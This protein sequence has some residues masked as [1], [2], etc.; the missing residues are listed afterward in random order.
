MSAP[1]SHSNS[2]WPLGSLAVLVAVLIA[3]GVGVASAILSPGLALDLISLWPGLIPALI[4]VVVVS[5]RRAW[6]R[7]IGA[8]PQ[9]L[10]LT[11]LA[12]GVAAHI[13]GWPP[14]PS[15]AAQLEG[16]INTF[17]SSS[18]DVELSGQLEVSA[19]DSPELYAVEFIRLG[20][21][22]GV[23]EA[24]EI[25]LEESISV[26]IHD[27]GTTPFFRYAGWR[28]SLS[29][30]TTWNLDLEGAIGAD[31]T[32]LVLSDVAATGGGWLRFGSYTTTTPL[33]L[34][35]GTFEVTVPAHSAVRITGE[36]QV[37][38]TWVV[39]N[40]GYRAPIEG[41]GLVISVIEGASVFIIEA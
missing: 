7:R 6:T 13:D 21:R 12:M 24:E 17:T 39:V 31:L 3:G 1:W 27:A 33:E 20:G 14:L 22:V 35:G 18:L 23:A 28:I 41:E 36:A 11:W 37:P 32:G 10:A 19:A 34:R 25:S 16:P 40:G 5:I 9:L 2:S 8:M 15:S 38:D 26:A 29:T 30:R 4:A